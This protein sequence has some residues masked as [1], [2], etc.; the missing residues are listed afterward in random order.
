MHFVTS[1][2]SQSVRVPVGPSSFA[3]NVNTRPGH[4]EPEDA[5]ESSSDIK[6]GAK[7]EDAGESTNHQKTKHD[8][9]LNN[10]H[11]Y[12]HEIVDSIPCDA[13]SLVYSMN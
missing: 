13:I 9:V 4:R 3:I 2:L 1:I 5:G 12:Q 8:H 7:S 10:S 11:A 6:Q